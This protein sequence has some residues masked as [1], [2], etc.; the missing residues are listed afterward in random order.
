MKDNRE[1]WMRR[2]PL[3]RTPDFSQS[4]ARF[5]RRTFPVA[6][7][8]NVFLISFAF[9]RCTITVFVAGLFRYPNGARPGY[10]PSF[11]LCFN[12]RDVFALNWRM[13]S[14]AMPSSTDIISTLSLG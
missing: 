11:A 4:S 6:Y 8:S 3:E 10:I 5:S 9:L 14:V 12:P 2:L 1:I 7:I 13:Y